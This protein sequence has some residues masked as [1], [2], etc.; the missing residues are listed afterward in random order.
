MGGSSI[1]WVADTSLGNFAPI[2]NCFGGV[3][4]TNE[5]V[6]TSQY[7]EHLA[8]N[9]LFRMQA[10]LRVAAKCCVPVSLVVPT[11]LPRTIVTFRAPATSQMSRLGHASA[12]KSMKKRFYSRRPQYGL[13]T[14]QKTLIGAGV[15]VVGGSLIFLSGAPRSRC[16]QN[17]AAHIAQ[18]E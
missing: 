18:P 16:C 7:E 2:G 11:G 14:L 1:G 8:A 4:R 13:T 3:G 17:S 12:T 9:T 5:C 15:V 10:V 6:A